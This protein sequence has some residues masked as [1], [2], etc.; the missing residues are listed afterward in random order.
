M[1]LFKKENYKWII[2]LTFFGLIFLPGKMPPLP[3]IKFSVV[4]LMGGLCLLYQ[5]IYLKNVVPTTENPKTDAR[6][7]LILMFLT[8]GVI[9]AYFL[10]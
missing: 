2:I 7:T 10:I 8:I 6:Q 3:A 4:G 5:L 1:A 9:V